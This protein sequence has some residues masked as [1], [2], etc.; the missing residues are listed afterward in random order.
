M[1]RSEEN[2][3]MSDPWRGFTQQP[4]TFLIKIAGIATAIAL[5]MDLLFMASFLADTPLKLVLQ[6]LYRNPFSPL[7][8]FVTAVGFGALGVTLC[9]KQPNPIRLNTSRLWALIL[10]L[11]GGLACKNLL[12]LPLEF[13]Q[14]SQGGFVGTVVGVFWKGR[15]Y[16]GIGR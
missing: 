13:V 7:L 8:P 5:A 11:L 15:P 10:C 14:L 1:Q 16:W 9:E 3:P 12:P 4:W 2:F 6:S